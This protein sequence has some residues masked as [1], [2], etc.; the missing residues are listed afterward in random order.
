MREPA[1]R[2]RRVLSGRVVPHVVLALLPRIHIGDP[3]QDTSSTGSPG[4]IVKDIDLFTTTVV[5]GA[6]NEVATHTNGSLARSRIINSARSHQAV[7]SFLLKFPINTPYSKL[8]IFKA[9]MERFVKARPREV[10]H[11][12]TAMLPHL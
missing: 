7:L 3:N 6:T 11:D 9:A 12:S 2:M 1:N 5:L 10:C 4:W 8:Q